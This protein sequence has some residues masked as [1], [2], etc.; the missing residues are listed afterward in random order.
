MSDLNAKELLDQEM[1]AIEK[2]VVDQHKK[3]LAEDIAQTFKNWKKE[4]R[5]TQEIFADL[6]GSSQ[7]RVSNILNGRVDSFTVD[8]LIGFCAR[9]ELSANIQ[10]KPLRN[11]KS[12]TKKFI[13]EIQNNN[14]A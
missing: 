14:A 1:S 13:E 6:I 12:G 8:K 2:K 11:M 4:Y 5:I 10:S 9:I 3:Q 7:P